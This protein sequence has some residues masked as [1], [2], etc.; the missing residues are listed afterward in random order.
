MPHPHRAC[1]ANFTTLK[2]IAHNLIRKA[3]SKP[4][5]RA[6]RSVVR[7]PI[8]VNRMLG[9]IAIQPLPF[10]PAVK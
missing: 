8:S 6:K 2:H 7:D 5:F 10:S 3:P 4:S 9:A 1:P